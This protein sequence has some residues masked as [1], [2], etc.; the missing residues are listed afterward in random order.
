M[1]GKIKIVITHNENKGLIG[2]RSPDCDPILRTF[3]GE[4]AA[5]LGIV[6]GIVEEARQLWAENPQFPKCETPLPSQA[7]PAKTAGSATAPKKTSRQES[8]F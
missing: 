8:M 6:P 5:G 1:S 2:V 3:E 7:V 4:L